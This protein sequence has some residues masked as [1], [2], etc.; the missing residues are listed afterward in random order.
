MFPAI[1]VDIYEDLK[2]GLATGAG[3]RIPV[4]IVEHLARRAVQPGRG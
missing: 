3:K 4:Q 1:I 2:A